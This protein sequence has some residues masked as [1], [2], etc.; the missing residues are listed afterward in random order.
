[1]FGRTDLPFRKG[2]TGRF[3]QWLVMVLV[4]MSA[5]AASV[6]TYTSALL[7]HWNRSVTG[8]LTVQIP[9]NPND[10][11][12]DTVRNVDKVLGVL[13]VHPAVASATLIPRDK[14]VAL[15]QPWLG[16]GEGV[17][18]LPLPALIDVRLRNDSRASAPSVTDAVA[19]AAPTAL[20][21]D[22][23]LWLS[24]VTSLAEGFGTIALLLMALIAAALT[25]TV[26]FATRASLTEFIQVIEVL[27]LVG[28]RDSYIAHQFARR[29]LIEGVVGG[30]CGLL[31]FAPALGAVLWLGARVE[32]G[33]LPEVALPL[34][35]WIVLAAL[36]LIAG[37]LAMATAHVT[38]SR[39]LR[40]MV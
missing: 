31:L 36:P 10:K 13:K 32:A 23:R 21:D 16:N 3:V 8:T 27:H 15:L 6:N 22:H 4:F 7:V 5:I 40:A 30:L 26:I 14:V 9:Q 20:V 37:L 2:A 35:L 1:M 38:V 12:D 33:V 11:A 17:N 25:L 19:K 18:D 39:A 28:A 24:R 34:T 29:A